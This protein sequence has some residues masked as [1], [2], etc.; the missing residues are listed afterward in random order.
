MLR[1]SGESLD[2]DL[3][4]LDCGIAPHRTWKKN[5]SRTRM[6]T[7]LHANSGANFVVSDADFDDFSGQAE[8][9]TKFLTEHAASVAKMT[10]HPGYKRRSWTSVCLWPKG[11]SHSIATYHCGLC[12]L[13]LRQTWRWKYLNTRAVNVKA[14]ADRADFRCRG[15]QLQGSI[16][17]T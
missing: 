6:G 11:S 13:L 9:A 16:T 3:M 12:N 1:I 4:V 10:A 14:A 5:E 7:A 8:A 15:P 17:I 2:V